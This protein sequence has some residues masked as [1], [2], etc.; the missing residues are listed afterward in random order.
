MRQQQHVLLRCRTTATAIGARRASRADFDP[1]ARRAQG[2][3]QRV[4]G[5]DLRSA[6][7]P[8]NP[9]GTG[10]VRDPFPGNIIPPDRISRH[11]ALLPVVPARSDQ[12]GLCRTTISGGLA[13]DRIQQPERHR[14]RSTSK[15]SGGNRLSVLVLPRQAQPGDAVPRRHGQPADG[16][17][18]ALY[19]DAAGR[20]DPN[21]ARRSSTRTCSARDG[22]IR[23]AWDSPGSSVPI[24]NATIEGEYPGNGGPEAGCRRRS[25]FV[26]PGDC[27]AGPNA[28]TQWRGTDARAFTEYLNNYTLQNNLTWARG[29]HAMTFGFQGQRMD[30]NERERA[31]GSLATFGFSNVQTAGFGRQHTEDRHGQRL[32]QLSP[33]RPRTRPTSS[34]TRRSPPSG[35]FDSD[36]FWAQD[37]GK[38]KPDLTVN[39]GLRYDSMKP[40]TEVEDRWSYFDADTAERGRKRLSRSGRVRRRS[41]N[42]C[43]CRT[44]IKTYYGVV[45]PRL[46]LAYSRG[47][48]TV[49]RSALRHQVFTAWRGGRARR[50]P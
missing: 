23:P 50:R 32:R 38:M 9:S 22:S 21:D 3:L 19:G 41:P 14:A 24:F 17:A 29:R 40:Y 30:A 26:V 16:A 11:L 28:P 25:G 18:A 6:N 37:D 33:G 34:R 48:R 2:R 8:A 47:N 43:R 49:L 13:A 7:D 1:D 44:P 46:G 27:F 10:F 5:A 31:Y 12:R 36:A 45:G 4:A 15:L 39:L 42:S 20:R 35:R